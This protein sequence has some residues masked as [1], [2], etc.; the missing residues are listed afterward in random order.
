MRNAVMTRLADLREFLE[1]DPAFVR[2]H[3]AEHVEKIDLYADGPAIVAKANWDL[4]GLLHKEGAEGV[5]RTL[6]PIVP[7]AIGP[8]A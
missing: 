8:A 3:L 7:F 6:R 5:N 2:S 1:S 4:L